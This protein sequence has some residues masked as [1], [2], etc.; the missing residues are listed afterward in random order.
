M[1]YTLKASKYEC[2]LYTIWITTPEVLQL[3]SSFPMRRWS[4]LMW[5]MK[6]TEQYLSNGVSYMGIALT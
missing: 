3:F 1:I 4:Q 6:Y 2:L 5:F